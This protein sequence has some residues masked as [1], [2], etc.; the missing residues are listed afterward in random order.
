[1]AVLCMACNTNS[2]EQKQLIGTWSEPYHVSK[3]V[4]SLTFNGDGT[5]I[6]IERRDTTWDPMSD[7]LGDE[8]ELNYTVNKNQLVIFGSTK[9][10]LEHPSEEFSFSSGYSIDGNTLTIDSF[11]YTGG[12]RSPFSKSLVLKK[13]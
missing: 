10:T 4:K 11:S 12:L 1:M 9:E 13:L 3:T 8:A 6:Y 5:L 7:W 2:P